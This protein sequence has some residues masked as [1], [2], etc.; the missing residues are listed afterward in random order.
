MSACL[1]SK[2]VLDEATTP[3]DLAQ[4]RRLFRAY[5]DWLGVDLCF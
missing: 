3:K 1:L 4:V 5:A 2:C